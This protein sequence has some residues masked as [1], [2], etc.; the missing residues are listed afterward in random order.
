MRK[1]TVRRFLQDPG[2]ETYEEA[3]SAYKEFKKIARKFKR[4]SFKRRF[5]NRTSTD[6]FL[7][8]DPAI[9][10]TIDNLSVK[11]TI[12]SYKRQKCLKGGRN[13]ECV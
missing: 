3:V 9:L 11:S 2:L 10:E 1:K 12:T 5:S 13:I 7:P 6:I 4:E 8:N